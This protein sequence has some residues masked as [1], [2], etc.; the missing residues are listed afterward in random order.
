MMGQK[1]LAGDK[2]EEE[3][4]V[5]VGSWGRT[6]QPLSLHLPAWGCRGS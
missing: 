4:E 1:S 5:A 3:R 2:R 6:C